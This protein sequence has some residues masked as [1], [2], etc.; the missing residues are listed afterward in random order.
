M[1]L[2]WLSWVFKVIISHKDFIKRL[3]TAVVSSKGSTG[4]G[5]TYKLLAGLTSL[6]VVGQRTPVS[7][8][9]LIRGQYKI[10]GISQHGNLPYQS[11]NIRR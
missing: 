8:W 3:V 9:L 7:H 11:T 6:L 1:N 10:L 4:G 2:A 5:L